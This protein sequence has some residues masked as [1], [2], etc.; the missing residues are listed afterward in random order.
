MHIAFAALVGMF[1]LAG[2][3]ILS[4]GKAAREEKAL[5]KKKAKKAAKE[6][7]RMT[8]PAVMKKLD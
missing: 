8:S 5:S 4:A 6:G 7:E 1:T 3:L 2:Y